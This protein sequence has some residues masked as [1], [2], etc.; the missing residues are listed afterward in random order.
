MKNQHRRKFIKNSGIVTMG[1][2]LTSQISV[3]HPYV[4]GASDRL[5]MAAIGLNGRGSSLIRSASKIP[6]S[7]I[8]HLCDVD[9]RAIEKGQSVLSSIGASP[10]VE[11]RD[12]RKILDNKDIDAVIIA[13]PDHWHA[14]M[15]IMAA[16]AGKA[17]YVEKPCCHNPAEGELLV[18]VRDKYNAIIQM[19][20]QQRSGLATKEVV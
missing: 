5:R 13:T 6:N 7:Q 8:T 19:G 20:N 14:P 4:L 18:K 12:F 16:K 17:V 2:V 15:A 10:A 9:S 1:A 11:V 3:A